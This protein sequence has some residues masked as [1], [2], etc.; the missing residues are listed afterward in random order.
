MERKTILVKI[1]TLDNK[2]IIKAKCLND[3]KT[4]ETVYVAKEKDKA[5]DRFAEFCKTECGFS[6]SAYHDVFFLDNT[7]KKK[8]ADDFICIWVVLIGVVSTR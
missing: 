1:E 6:D 2:R 8:F 4:F 5:Y 3:G 7:Q